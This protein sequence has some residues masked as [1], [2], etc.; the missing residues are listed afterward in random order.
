[1]V[2]AFLGLAVFLC[3][4]DAEAQVPAAQALQNGNSEQIQDEHFATLDWNT[5]LVI[6]LC[7]KNLLIDFDNEV[8]RSPNSYV[9]P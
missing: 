7:I 1:M 9:D 6:H 5:T 2:L 8:C 4:I 3:C